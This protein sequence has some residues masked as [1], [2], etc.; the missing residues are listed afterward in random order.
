MLGQEVAIGVLTGNIPPRQAAAMGKLINSVLLPAAVARE[1]AQ[2]PQR[3]K[4]GQFRLSLKH[5]NRLL[6]IDVSDDETMGGEADTRQVI[7]Q[8]GRLVQ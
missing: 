6:E 2:E 1:T 7:D 8:D 5:Q 3:K 4:E